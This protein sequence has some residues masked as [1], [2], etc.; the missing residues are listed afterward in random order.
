MSVKFS[1][2]PLEWVNGSVKLKI[3][4]D[5]NIYIIEIRNQAIFSFSMATC[6]IFNSATL[7][8]TVAGL[9]F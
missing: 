2:T 8:L 5:G 1:G 4:H 9:P 3:G 7:P 6:S